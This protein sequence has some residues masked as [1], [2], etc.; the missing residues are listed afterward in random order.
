M[1]RRIILLN[2]GQEAEYFADFLEERNPSLEVTNVQTRQA[3][4][5]AV[6][7]C[8]GRARLISF[9]TDI[10][11]PKTVLEQLTL[12]PYNIH[13][14][15][16]EYPGSHPES[17]AIWEGA[18]TYGVTAHEM[19]SKVD[20]GAI[21]AV[22]RYP[23]PDNP[24]RIALNDFT[25]AQALKVFAVV[26]AHCA[27]SDDPMPRMQDRWGMKKRT[28]KDFAALCAPTLDIAPEALKTLEAACGPDL[29]YP[30]PQ[31]SA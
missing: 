24:R 29:N 2:G 25:Y 5:D 27:D 9:L 22:L 14:G 7:A 17:W 18:E 1:T 10:I 19:V 12:T 21:V 28:K 11:V 26:A 13:P 3:L 4:E 23:M 16:P 30:R 15:P 20:A 8:N 6:A 31:Q